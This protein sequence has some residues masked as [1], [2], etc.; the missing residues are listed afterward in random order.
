MRLHLLKIQIDKSYLMIAAGS[1]ILCYV[2]CNSKN[3]FTI[4]PGYIAKLSLSSLLF[5]MSEPVLLS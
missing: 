1:I 4:L 2:F 3:I 5:N